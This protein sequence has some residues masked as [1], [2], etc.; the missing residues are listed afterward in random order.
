MATQPEFDSV[1]SL[2]PYDQAIEPVPI[3]AGDLPAPGAQPAPGDLAPPAA[4]APSSIS[5]VAGVAEGGARSG[6]RGWVA[7]VAIGAV[8]VIA[9]A[10]LSYFLVNTTGQRDAA[11]TELAST[12]VAL[13]STK[14]QLATAQADAA[15]KK[16]T[17]D[18]VSLYVVNSGRV[19]TDYEEIVA[20]TAYSVCRTAAQQLLT[21]L[22]SFQSAR[23]S[24]SV[25][26]TLSNS[27]GML[28]DSI[29]SGIAGTQEFITGMDTDSTS[30]ITDGLTK[31][32]AAML[33]MGKAETALGAAIN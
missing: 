19:Q 6:R 12:R 22:Q 10:S 25:P 8:G 21:D 29:S 27:D 13:A 24:A 17:A 5:E 7:P 33:A 23:T 30:K 26:G 16:I 28:G 14:T 18:Y 31:V 32:D 15:S 9:A 1:V 2:R 4:P 20:C 11:R 3:P